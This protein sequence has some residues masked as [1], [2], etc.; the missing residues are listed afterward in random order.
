MIFIMIF[1]FQVFIDDS[2]ES[3]LKITKTFAANDTK[4]ILRFR[5]EKTTFTWDLKSI[6]YDSSGSNILLFPQNPIGA[7]KGLSYFSEGP[8]VFSGNSVVL[9]FNDSFQVGFRY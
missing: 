4:V 1:C 6:E 2:R 7:Q 3:L 8:V 5:F 9:R